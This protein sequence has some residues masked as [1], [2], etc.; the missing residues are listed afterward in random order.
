MLNLCFDIGANKGLY[1]D[2]NKSKFK[3][4]LIIDANPACI[5]YLTHKFTSEP[6]VYIVNAIVSSNKTETFYVC[7]QADTI[8]TS[9][10]EW[11]TNSR[12]S[13]DY[14][15][16]PVEHLQTISLDTCIHIYGKP[17]RIKIDVEG[18]ELNVC[19]SLTQ[20]VDELCFEWAEEKQKECIETVEYLETIGF[21]QFSIQ[22]EDNY[23]YIPSIFLSKT[24]TIDWLNKNTNPSRK[25]L[26]GM[27]WCR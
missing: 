22:L 3:S 1:T 18:Y 12:F 4:F 21:T 23:L 6:N 27:I 5:E 14:T 25:Q 16:K 10:K 19:K 24:D 13:K 8:S 9:D 7:D 2:A 17:D 26:W 11:I 15:W 20:K